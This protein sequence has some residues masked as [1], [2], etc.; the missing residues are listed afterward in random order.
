MLPLAVASIKITKIAYISV[1]ISFI[2]LIRV[3]TSTFPRLENM[4]NTFIL[5]V[6]G[7]VVERSKI[8]AGVCA[9]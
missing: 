1:S 6:L 3:S 9:R 5:L 8:G 7:R 2:C 4:L